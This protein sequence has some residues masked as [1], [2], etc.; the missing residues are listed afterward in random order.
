[1]TTSE[2]IEDA[3][4]GLVRESNTLAGYYERRILAHTSY[5]IFVG[6]S[7]PSGYFKLS[8]AIPIDQPLT[9][10]EEEVEGFRVFTETIP[11]EELPRVSI[12]ITSLAYRDIFT[13]LAADL[14]DR[15]IEVNDSTQ[16]LSILHKR[17]AHWKR[18]LAS[19]LNG[20]SRESQIGLFGELLILKEL[21]AVHG[22][23]DEAV[24]SWIGPIKKNQD[25]VL[26]RNAI[27]VKTTSSNDISTVQISNEFQ[28]DTSTFDHLFLCHVTIEERANSGV[29]L[30]ALIEEI[31]I[32]LNRHSRVQF[33]DF[34]EEAGYSCSQRNLY[35]NTGYIERTRN[36]YLV[37]DLFPRVTPNMLMAGISTIKYCVDMSNVKHLRTSQTSVFEA[38]F[39][40]K[41]E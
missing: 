24:N 7:L 37:S 2:L 35:V 6:H 5:S 14:I 38:Y 39:G 1:M 13:V 4:C 27:E 31:S 21:M 34:L 19:G 16:L 36:Y 41:H 33:L 9:N 12:E 8:F 28:L 3:W 17:I 30:P 26:L 32:S 23:Q 40:I 18:F 22:K 20:M 15:L 11:H 29:T 25:F 10:M